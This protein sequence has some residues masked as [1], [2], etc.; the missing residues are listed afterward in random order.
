MKTEKSSLKKTVLRA[1]M[2]GYK[3]YKQKRV[4]L[5]GANAQKSI[6]KLL[7]SARYVFLMTSSD[8]A[9]CC[10]ARYVQPVIE[11][12]GN[13]FKVWIGTYVKSRKVAE[14]TDRTNVTLALGNDSAGANLIIHG[15]ATLHTDESVRVKYWKPEWRMF[16]PAG[17]TDPDAIAIC[18]TPTALELMDFK[19]NV[20]PE[21]FG[22]RVLQLAWQ[23]N[24]WNPVTAA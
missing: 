12:E 19:R 8:S 1:L 14:L 23:D 5:G 18:V 9:R 15:T 7:S 11:W 20:I 21:P 16:F 24:Q 22:L 17:P 13:Q 4:D 6:R 10:N 2:D 3:R